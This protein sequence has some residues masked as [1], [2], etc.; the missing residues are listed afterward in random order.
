MNRSTDR[1]LPDDPLIERL[2]GARPEAPDELLDPQAPANQAILRAI[3][4]GVEVEGHDSAQTPRKRW[5]RMALT[6]AAIAAVAGLVVVSPF[7]STRPSAAEVV[8]SA[9]VTSRSALDSGRASLTV[10]SGDSES[11]STSEDTYDYRFAGDDVDV[12]IVLGSDRGGGFPGERRIVDGEMYW[13]FGGDAS[14]PWFHEAGGVPSRSDWTSDPR[15]LLAGLEPRAGFEIVGHDPMGGVE[16]THLRATTPGK[17]DASGLSLGEATLSGGTVTNLD[18]WVDGDHVVRRIDLR[19]TQPMTVQS[20][21]AA[22][23]EDPTGQ[24]VPTGPPESHTVTQVT[25]ASVRF[26][27]IGRVNTIEAPENA[28]D[29]SL[30]DMAH[31]PPPSDAAGG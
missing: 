22:A 26:S 28:R 7:G 6:A 19:M 18:V 14:T 29:V 27:D 3:I 2:R 25:E 31:P 9:A 4:H 17:I 12:D 15:T 8:R 10:K 13:H 20:V 16:A 30:A 23:A 24:P 5:P 21:Q 11:S 1:L